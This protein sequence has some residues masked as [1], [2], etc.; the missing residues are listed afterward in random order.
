MLEGGEKERVRAPLRAA[1]SLDAGGGTR[2]D[3]AGLGAGID[4]EGDE[5]TTAGT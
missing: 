5:A 3:G 1:V 4:A 2:V